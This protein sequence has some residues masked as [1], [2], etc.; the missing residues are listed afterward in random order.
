M[1]FIIKTTETIFEKFEKNFEKW[2]TK[3]LDL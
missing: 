1:S 2:G 3:F